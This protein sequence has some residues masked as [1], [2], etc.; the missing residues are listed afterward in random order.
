MSEAEAAPKWSAVAVASAGAFVAA[1]STSLV[2]VA[3][4]AMARDLHASQADVGWVLSAYLLT[5][6]GVLAGVG[7]LADVL[8]RRRVYLTGYIVFGIA[9]LAC[10][11]AAT[12]PLLVAARVV[13]GLGAAAL[14]ATGPGIITRAFPARLRARGL[15]LQLTATYAGLTLGPTIGGALTS[16]L[17]WHAVFFAVAGAAVMGAG[18]A[19]LL[20]E[21]DEKRAAGAPPLDVRGSVLFAIGIATLLIALRRGP[22]AGGSVAVLLVIAVAAFVLFARHEARHPAPV[23]PLSLL[24]TPAFAFGVVGAMLLYVVVFILSWLLP[25]QLQ[26]ERGMNASH[27]GVLMAAQPAMMAIVAPFSGWLSDRFGPRLPSV[28][29]MLVMA[30]GMALMGRAA[31]SSDLH[32][33]VALAI[34]G[35]GTGLYV[36]P[37]NAV[38]MTAAPRD[39]QGTAGA[40][41]A[42]ARNIGMTCGVA[43]AVVLHDA[44]GFEGAL[45]AAAAIALLGALL[46]AVR[47]RARTPDLAA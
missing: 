39:R 19:A 2:A 35:V 34:V 44:V 28:T 7:R 23:L 47:P 32:L 3:A 24:R 45:A 5:I 46:G 12:L 29:G 15:G 37:N 11:A 4:P 26:R 8:G 40:I 41:A 9:S 10:A 30:T 20:L 33:V 43:L 17:G 31:S 38:I 18:V 27:A 13:Q 21:P 14:M 6:S 36:A 1:L 22:A 16:A 42:T 25:F